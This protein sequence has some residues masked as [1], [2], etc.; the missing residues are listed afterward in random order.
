M[1]N[2][3]KKKQQQQTYDFLFPSINVIF[4]VAYNLDAIFFLFKKSIK[5]N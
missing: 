2:L 5:L 3:F 4:V 1:I